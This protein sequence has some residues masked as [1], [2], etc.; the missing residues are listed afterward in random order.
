MRAT[1]LLL[2]YNQ[3]D[4]VSHAVRAALAQV[5][6]P[7]QIFISDDA[8]T[9]NTFAV[10]QSTVMGYDGHHQIT[11]NRN[12]HNLGIAGHINASMERIKTDYVIAAAGD[13]ISAPNRSQLILECFDQTTALLV[14]SRTQDIDTAG[15]LLKHTG[16]H[17]SASFF[18]TTSAK[19]LVKAM[20]LYIG[21]TGAWH[22]EL[23]DRFG[24]LPKGCYEDLVL[25]YRAS[26][27]DR[28]AMID[29]ALVQYRAGIGVSAEPSM[30]ENLADS[31]KLR[32]KELSHSK[33]VF[34]QRVLDNAIAHPYDH[35]FIAEELRLGIL[36]AAV[37][38]S[39][40]QSSF[41]SVLM[42]NVSSAP[43]LLK[44][45]AS[46]WNRSRRAMR[47]IS[48]TALLFATEN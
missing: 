38:M 5:G 14:H 30:P 47:S 48:R 28:V 40:H 34:E 15:N 17:N 27:L 26:L 3:Q 43:F 41:M 44:E 33:A 25:G 10:I 4:Y 6:E 20:A 39:F 16:G 22:R 45:L 36:S 12:Q 37:R 35:N 13:D 18:H 7:L 9:D 21:A 8:S 32:L 42:R 1:F 11:L 31:R 19:Q 29:K 2:T 24:D 46:E 23:F